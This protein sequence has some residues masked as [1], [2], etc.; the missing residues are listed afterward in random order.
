MAKSV[1]AL[2]QELAQL[3][4]QLEKL[5]GD[6]EQWDKLKKEYEAFLDGSATTK[7]FEPDG[8]IDV[9]SK[10]LSKYKETLDQT[11]NS[12]LQTSCTATIAAQKT[13]LQNLIAAKEEE[14]RQKEQELQNAIQ[15]A[16]AKG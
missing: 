8:G 10:G 11:F 1:E 14:I 6:K 9:F 13:Q 2:S 16:A 7:I 5:E 3:K 4:K 12:P 15:A